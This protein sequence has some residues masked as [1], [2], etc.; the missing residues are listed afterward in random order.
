M[1]DM[2]VLQ[3]RRKLMVKGGVGRH[4]P[5]HNQ[6]VMVLLLEGVP[7]I[8]SDDNGDPHAWKSIDEAREWTCSD[9]V[10]IAV[11][12]AESIVIVDL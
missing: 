9:Q 2:N 8:V 12:S 5:N 3:E 4:K 7:R 11:R 6:V 1:I 10:S